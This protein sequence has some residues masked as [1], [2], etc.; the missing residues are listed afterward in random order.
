MAHSEDVPHLHPEY[1]LL[2]CM[3]QQALRDCHREYEGVQLEAAYWL[4]SDA[5]VLVEG[6][7]GIKAD[8]FARCMEAVIPAALLE[9]VWSMTVKEIEEL[10]MGLP[11]Q[12]ELF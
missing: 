2:V 6:L 1:A 7:A 12:E 5:P 8:Y 3:I 11:I 4:I 10:A 9:R